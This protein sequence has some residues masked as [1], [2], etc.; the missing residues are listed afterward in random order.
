M[1]KHNYISWLLCACLVEGQI[2]VFMVV[3]TRIATPVLGFLPGCFFDEA[4]ER[5]FKL[6]LGTASY[7]LLCEGGQRSTCFIAL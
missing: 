1:H 6:I 4:G 3:L 7:P 2:P 5:W